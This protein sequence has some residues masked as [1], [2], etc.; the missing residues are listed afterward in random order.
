MLNLFLDL[1]FCI[2]TFSLFFFRLYFYCLFHNF[3]G[4]K[5][6]LQIYRLKVVKISL[7]LTL[8]NN[9]KSLLFFQIIKRLRQIFILLFMFFLTFIQNTKILTKETIR[10]QIILR[11]IF[12]STCPMIFFILVNM[13]FSFVRLHLIYQY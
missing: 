5:L 4:Q 10:A 7:L 1:F 3:N 2:F 13:L 6:I 12:I 9:N 11:F 8:E